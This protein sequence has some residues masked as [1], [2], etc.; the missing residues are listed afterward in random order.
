M[1]P[2]QEQLV[3]DV[4]AQ[5]ERG[6]APWVRPWSVSGT[7]DMP[8]NLS[9]HRAYNGVNVLQLWIA[10][11]S[12]AYATAEWCTFRQAKALGAAVRKGEHGTPV[13]FIA[14]RSTTD[15]DEDD[16]SRRTGVTFK[17]YTVFNRTQCEG[18]PP[19]AAVE[20]LSPG[21]R[22][23]DAEAYI[24]AIGADVRYAGDAAFFS[25]VSDF[26]A[27]PPRERFIDAGSYYGTLLHEHIHWTGHETR[28]ARTFGKRF[29]DDA[30]ATEELIA[31]L[32]AA[33]L[34][35]QL[36]ITGSL[37]HVEYLGHW[38]QV[39]RAEP[40][41]LWTAGAAATKAV[42]FLDGAAGRDRAVDLADVA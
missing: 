5:L 9:T 15:R 36:A 25:R 1:K 32:G 27:C 40:K 10:Q 18:L 13:W 7:S 41:A 29:G 14:P 34:T 19:I 31:E 20:P 2:A 26:I 22:L 35:A 42:A 33:F 11:T 21:E 16:E 30:Y 12:C 24:A 6:T 38:A 37:R 17:Q 8:H 39:L 28:L 23:A 4:I 3:A